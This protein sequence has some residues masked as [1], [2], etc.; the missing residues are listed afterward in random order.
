[1]KIKNIIK[2]YQVIFFFLL[3]FI[4]SW[5]NII[6]LA[7]VFSTG[8]PASSIQFDRLYNELGPIIM[9]PFLFGPSIAG[10]IM[11]AIVDGKKG[12]RNLWSS[13]LR[14]KFNIRWY[15]LA[16]LM[17]PVF[18]IA[19]LSV[20]SAI[21]PEFLPQIVT[22][23][24]KL[25]ILLTGLGLGFS[26]IFEEI[27]WTG[28][29]T[30]KLRERYGSLS[31]GLIVG[32]IW[33]IWH[34][35]PTIWASG[36]PTGSLSF[37]LFIGPFSFYFLVL[38]IFRVIMV[39]VY[40]YTKSLLFAT[41]MHGSLTANTVIILSPQAQGISLTIYY[42]ILALVFLI[43]YLAMK[44]KLKTTVLSNDTE[45]MMSSIGSHLKS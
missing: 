18:V 19:I 1:M 20:F 10:I 32:F 5:G 23:D 21:S 36:D 44:F 43:F 28:Y 22:S 25:V 40:D 12:F 15:G 31:T 13:L 39:K 6:V 35:M 11:T 24:S 14:W 37:D 33:G 17:V 42:V 30:P 2:K 16:I 26:T 3:T 41:L 45:S 4:I 34:L 38:P 8:V 29:V 9:M 7:I 27:G